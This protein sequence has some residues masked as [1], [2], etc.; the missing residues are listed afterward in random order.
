MH[1]DA[2]YVLILSTVEHRHIEIRVPGH[3]MNGAGDALVIGDGAPLTSEQRPAFAVVD[4][5]AEKVA[6]P[7]GRLRDIFHHGG[8]HICRHTQI[9]GDHRTDRGT[10]ARPGTLQGARATQSSKKT[11]AM[12][13]RR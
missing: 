5:A 13:P 1:H 8:V 2:G 11:S 9:N 10:P 4:S 12:L 3:S 6:G 7:L